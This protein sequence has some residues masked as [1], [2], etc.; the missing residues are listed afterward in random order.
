MSPG[1]GQWSGKDAARA[2]GNA[3]AV[4]AARK[5]GEGAGPRCIY[6]A[7]RQTV[8]V[9]KTPGMAA[10]SRVDAKNPVGAERGEAR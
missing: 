2:G 6:A 5:A 9:G 7:R 3:R 10:S 8:I 4:L 1:A